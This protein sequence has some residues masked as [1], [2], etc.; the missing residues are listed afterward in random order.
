MQSLQYKNKR[1]KNGRLLKYSAY[2][3]AADFVNHS[4]EAISKYKI[5]KDL[6]QSYNKQYIE[7]YFRKLIFYE[8]L[9]IAHQLVIKE[10]D[11]NHNHNNGN[12]SIDASTLTCNELLNTFQNIDNSVIFDYKGSL[13]GLQF[14]KRKYRNTLK[15]AIF[16]YHR[17]LYS[18][19]TKSS[20]LSKNNSPKIAVFLV[21]GL[22]LS[23]RSDI[24]WLSDSKIKPS[25]VLIYFSLKRSDAKPVISELKKKNIQ[26]VNLRGWSCKNKSY[27]E[28]DAFN[29]SKKNNFSTNIQDWL[30]YEV[31]YLLNNINYWYSFFKYFKIK[32]HS[33]KTEYGL[34]T[35]VKQISLEKLNGISFVSQRSN[36]DPQKGLFYA[37]YP[38]DIFFSWGLDS[39]KKNKE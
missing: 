39:V 32:V 14:F 37:Y 9:P 13:S 20:K 26:W 28:K 5:Y 22:D 17:V 16:F 21:E 15:K 2:K 33:D 1:D 29:L 30:N 12:L 25:S 10:W 24:F 34:E 7:F 36:I 4:I 8:F 38:V 11:Y 18:L 31:E 3:L 27:L 19:E 35:I 23:K 6:S